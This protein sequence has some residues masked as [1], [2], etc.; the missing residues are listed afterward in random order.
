[1]RQIRNETFSHTL[2]ELD[3]KHFIQCQFLQCKLVFTAYETV[4]FDGCVFDQ[5]DW[6]FD[7]PAE[8][9]LKFLSALYAGLRPQGEL[10]VEEI[11]NGVRNG[12]IGDTIN[13]REPLIVP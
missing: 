10:L 4:A 13:L 11:L 3:G 6:V 8:T 12:R 9:T 7:G 1:M 5:C 2:I